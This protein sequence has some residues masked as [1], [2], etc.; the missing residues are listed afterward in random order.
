MVYRR[1]RYYRRRRPYPRRRFTRTK[2][3]FFRRRR[4]TRR[5]I[6][7]YGR[8]YNF[9]EK[10][11]YTQFHIANSTL[12]SSGYAL[13]ALDLPSWSN[14]HIN[15]DQ[16]KIYKWKIVIA[17][18]KIQSN[19]TDTTTTGFVGMEMMRHYLGYDYGDAS[20]PTAVSTMLGPSVI[21]TNWNRPLKMIIRPRVAKPI[22][23]GLT[24]TGYGPGTAWIDVDDEAVPHYGFKYFLDNSSWILQ[25][26][27]PELNCQVW[28]T[29]YYGF[30]NVNRPG[31]T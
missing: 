30:R 7:W 11:M 28:Y 21:S 14:R 1:R 3:R 19:L 6:N 10:F 23:E 29:V 18:P 24:D 22:Y 9:K 16:Y 5:K 25:G 12:V 31:S 26:S 20:P 13:K 2:R 8:K 17:P 4:Y 15:F 27:M